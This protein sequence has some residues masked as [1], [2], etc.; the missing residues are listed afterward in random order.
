[1]NVIFVEA[2]GKHTPVSA[3]SSFRDSTS[4][5]GS[6]ASSGRG[7]FNLRQGQYRDRIGA[8]FHIHTVPHAVVVSTNAA[9]E[10]LFSVKTR[11]GRAQRVMGPGRN[12]NRGGRS[13]LPGA[14]V[15]T[16]D[17]GKPTLNDGI[18]WRAGWM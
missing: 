7:S 13:Q 11:P 10:T 9:G 1:M 8:V 17:L 3:N 18:S 15:V 5:Q 2:S 14:F 12:D 6:P 16:R 4:V